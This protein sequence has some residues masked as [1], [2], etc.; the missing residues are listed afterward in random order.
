MSA[1]SS[2]NP[3]GKPVEANNLKKKHCSLNDSTEEHIEVK[4]LELEQ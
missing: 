4:E 1:S 2:D 3:N